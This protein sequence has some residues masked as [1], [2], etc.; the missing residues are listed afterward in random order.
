MSEIAQLVTDISKSQDFEECHLFVLIHGLWGG[1]NHMITIEKCLKE[2][3]GGTTD[4]KIVILRPSSFRFWKTYDGLKICAERVLIEMFYEIETLMKNNLKVTDISI[5]GYSLGGLIGR[6]LIGILEELKFFNYV[7]PVFFSTFATPHVG[8]EFF[9]KTLFDKTANVLGKYLFGKSG[10]QLFMAD[11]EQ[12]LQKMAD[13]D[14]P[15]M[16]GLKRFQKR[17]LVANIKND[18]T[19]AFFTSFIT[20]YAPFDK[21][22]IIKVKYLKNL[23]TIRIGDAYVRGKVVDFARTAFDYTQNS[24]Y[25]DKN[26][27]ELT[28]ITRQSQVTRLIFLLFTALVFFPIWVPTVLTLSALTSIYSMIKIRILTYPGFKDHWERVKEGVFG[29]KPINEQDLEIGNKQRDQRKSLQKHETFKGDTSEFTENAMEGILYVEG[30]LLGYKSEIQDDDSGDNELKNK[31]STS[32]L[33]EGLTFNLKSD[34]DSDYEQTVSAS[35]NLTPVKQLNLM[36]S[37]KKKLFELDPKLNDKS[38]KEHEDKLSSIEYEN[39]PVFV[40]ENKLPIGKDKRFIIDN[41]NALNWIKMPVYLDAWNAHDGVVARRG[42]RSN[43]KGTATITLWV[44]V[45]RNHLKELE[46]L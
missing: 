7:T 30:K 21:F 11:T 43:P 10:R 18:K 27:Q 26:V 22:H 31:S 37:R 44:S 23:P 45:L 41:L 13:P 24:I 4:K 12:I 20:D 14:L 1:P 15:Y 29:T 16:K 46:E 42:P 19:V 36:F 3:V 32:T 17:T 8:I 40:K 25:I 28:H 39:Y 5:V 35:E 38:M 6:Y 2:L 9:N 33:S 34:E